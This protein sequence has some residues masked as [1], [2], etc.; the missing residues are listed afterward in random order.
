MNKHEI[1]NVCGTL[2]PQPKI[3]HTDTENGYVSV[4][5]RVLIAKYNDCSF[6]IT[7]QAPSFPLDMSLDF[8]LSKEKKQKLSFHASCKAYQ[9][10]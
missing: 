7:P 9:K 2:P 1:K 4:N 8:R 5:T 6:I 10:H 3:L